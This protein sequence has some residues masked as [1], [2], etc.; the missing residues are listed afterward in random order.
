[1]MFLFR[2]NNPFIVL[3]YA[4]YLISFRLVY[5]INPLAEKTYCAGGYQ[6][7][8]FTGI[9]PPESW[10]ALLGGAIL[11]GIQ[12]LIVNQI[13][14]TNRFSKQK[15]YYAGALYI[16]LASFLP[17]FLWFSTFS[18]GFTLILLAT[19]YHFAA[20][21]KEQAASDLFDIGFLL[22]LA[23]LF[24][25]P[26]LL[27]FPL[28]LLWQAILRPSSLR[29]YLALIIGLLAPFF[30]LISVDYLAN[31]SVNYSLLWQQ[32]LFTAPAPLLSFRPETLI[33]II[34][35]ILLLLI[36]FFTTQASLISSLI[37]IRKQVLCMYLLLAFALLIFLL[38]DRCD[39]VQL[40]PVAFPLS[41]LLM[42]FL[43][44][45]RVVWLGEVLHGILILIVL[46]N[47]YF[48][49]INSWL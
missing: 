47:Q 2:T 9:M 26:F 8:D 21:G 5:F 4:V 24:Y 18:L 16:I 36:T 20:T 22:S 43:Q 35:L 49:L 11:T 45:Q 28:F 41:V 25:F 37:Q 27:L 12:A 33:S 17:S 29:E 10:M 48:Y 7:F 32:S 19:L 31:L 42:F 3:L 23:S 44:Q 34:S 6:L 30:M 40:L 46:L 38:S 15:N 39:F 14:Q 13:V 1:M